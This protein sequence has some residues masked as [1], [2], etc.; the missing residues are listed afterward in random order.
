MDDRMVLGIK[1]ARGI[2]ATVEVTALFLLLRMNDLPSMVRL[3][4]LLGM[5]GPVIF[6]T[7][8]AMGLAGS[9]GQMPVSKLLLIFAGVILILLGTRA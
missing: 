6:I 1:L 9:V 7:V 5:V 8:M 2:S 4:G 3:N